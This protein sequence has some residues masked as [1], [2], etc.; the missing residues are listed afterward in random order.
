M[1]SFFP[2]D[3]LDEILNFI[4]SVFRGFTY[5]LLDL[6]SSKYDSVSIIL[7]VTDDC[8]FQLKG[9]MNVEKRNDKFP[10]M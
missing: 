8:F 1:L 4:G 7:Q 6:L 5:L 3:V 2:R 9:Q 10:Q